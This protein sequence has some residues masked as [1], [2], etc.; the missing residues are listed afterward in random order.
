M[1]D[2][3]GSFELSIFDDELLEKNRDMLYTKTSLFITA[4]VRKD[5]GGARLT[6]SAISKLELYLSNQQINW[7]IEI[8]NPKS[9]DMVKKWLT[10]EDKGVGKVGITLRVH[11][12][13]NIIDMK[14]PDTY[15]P[16]LAH[17]SSANLPEGIISIC[18]VD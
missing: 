7:L 16:N 2:P 14:L 15:Y 8:D 17:F 3:T 9:I 10:N 18:Q 12:E 13:D 11:V 4:D 6:A 5:A 1:S